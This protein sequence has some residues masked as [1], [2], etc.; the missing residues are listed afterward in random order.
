MLPT[1]PNQSLIDGFHCLEVLAGR[2]SAVGVRELARELGLNIT[3]VQRLLKTLAH[4]GL[5]QQLADRK[6]VVGPG[7]HVLSALTLFASGL[8]RRALGP[9]EELHRF[10]CLVAMGVLWRR[11]VSYFYH[12]TPGM[13]PADAMGRV[14]LFPASLSS[15]GLVLLAQQSEEQVRALYEGHTIEGFANADALVDRLREVREAGITWVE[16]GTHRSMAAPVGRPAS[17]AIALAGDT[18]KFD[19]VEAIVALTAAAERIAAS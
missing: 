13:K 11:H 10:N 17:A 9:L 5:T 15:I 18:R 16:H 4:L 14:E 2:A 7:V 6:Y 3:R 12:A 19:V 1:Q 8:I